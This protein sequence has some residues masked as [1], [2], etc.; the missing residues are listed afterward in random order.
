[1]IFWFVDSRGKIEPTVLGGVAIA[2]SLILTI[3]CTVSTVTYIFRIIGPT[4]GFAA[5]WAVLATLIWLVRR[6]YKVA[7]VRARLGGAR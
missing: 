4:A 7:C 5:L 2:V 1:M 6:E 3:L